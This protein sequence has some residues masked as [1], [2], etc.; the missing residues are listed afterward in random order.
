MMITASM[1]K[2]LREST[3]VGMMDCKK[4]LEA[5][6]GNMEEAINWLRE[7]GLS[8]AA[9]KSSRIAAEGLAAIMI[10]GNKASIVEI[11]SET[12]FVAKN[13]EFVSLVDTINKTIINNDAKTIEEA[14]QLRTDEV[15]IADLVIAKTAKIGEKLSFRRF[16][17][18][19]KNDNEVF[20]SYIHLGG[21]IAVLILLEGGNEE[22][23]KDIA[24]HA[25]AMRP[26]YLNRNEVSNEVLEKEKEIITEQAINEG[27]PKEIALKMVTGRI[28]K[29][30][31]EVCLEEQEFV[32]NS[33]L[34]VDEYVKANNG[35]I[36][37]MYR[38]E[39]G[40]GIEKKQENF[41]EE[42]MNQINK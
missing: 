8:K 37:A 23:A 35:T 2:E 15:T 7:N 19:I 32:K 33:D 6:S 13:E 12:D 27:K 39:V 11:N 4:A 24:M 26:Q 1:V 9:K 20:G 3:G 28:E 5:T 29:F 38:Y 14:E 31:K 18:V 30:Y 34:T 16:A 36:K 10:D 41:A 21:K 25:A 22:V 17:K 40:E 42:V